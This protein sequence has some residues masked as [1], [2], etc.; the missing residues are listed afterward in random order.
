M[1]NGSRDTRWE[2]VDEKGTC[3]T[4]KRFRYQETNNVTVK[5]MKRKEDGEKG[6]DGKRGKFNLMS[7]TFVYL[8][9]SEVSNTKRR[10]SITAF[11]LKKQHTHTHTH[12]NRNTK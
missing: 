3:T 8:T 11:S 2:F 9:E 5:V 1:M 12:T 10:I 6:D 7:L 4:N